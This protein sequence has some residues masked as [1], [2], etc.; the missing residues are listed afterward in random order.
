MVDPKLTDG[1][2]RPKR[3]TGLGRIPAPAKRDP[4]SGGLSSSPVQAYRAASRV[5]PRAGRRG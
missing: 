2:R 5:V 4:A 3:K 1:P